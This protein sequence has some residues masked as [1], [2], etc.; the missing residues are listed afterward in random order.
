MIN[1]KVSIIIPTYKRSERLESAIDSVLNQTYRNIEVLIVDDNDPLSDY[2]KL[3][4]ERMQ[5]YKNIEN[6]I[7]IK[8][9]KNKNGAAARNTGIQISKGQYIGFLDDDDTFFSEKIEKQVDFL[10]KNNEYN[11]VYCG[12]FQN[13]EKKFAELSGDLSKEILLLSFTPMTSTLLFREQ[14]LKTIGGFDENFRRHQDFELLLK[15]FKQFKIGAIKDVLLD[16]GVN[17]GENQLHGME[18]ENNKTNFLNTFEDV[19]N[20]ITKKDKRFKQKVYIRHYRDVFYDHISTN[21]FNL[22]YKT[23]VCNCKISFL[24]FNFEL[25]RYIFYYIKV[26]TI[27]CLSKF[28]K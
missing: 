17:D 13:G 16:V 24:A 10:K 28:Q 2:R 9:E 7:Y 5:K 15:Y 4:E 23:Y 11:A 14:A 22:A 27:K 19:I 8:H 20:D 21:H 26:K 6:V 18:L 25:I 1:E 12:R 3:T